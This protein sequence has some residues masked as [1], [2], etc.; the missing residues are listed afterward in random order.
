MKKNSRSLIVYLNIIIIFSIIVFSCVAKNVAYAEPG[1][2]GEVI[3]GDS[4]TENP[5]NTTE[6]SSGDNTGVNQSSPQTTAPSNNQNSSVSNTAPNSSGADVSAMDTRLSELSINCG[7]LIP[8]FSPDIYEYVVYVTKNQESKNCGTLATA[9]DSSATITADGPIE[10]NKEDV[11][12]KI[13]VTGSNGEKTEYVI[14]VHI[15]QDT[16]LVIENELYAITEK[17]DL[18]L[19]PSGFILSDE[20]LNGQE[21]KAAKSSDGNL[22]LVEYLATSNES[23]KWY[24]ISLKNNKI[25]PVDVK[26][27]GGEKYVTVSSEGNLLYGNGL[28]GLGYYL[29]NTETGEIE[30]F[31]GKN[32]NGG[33]NTNANDKIIISGVLIIVCACVLFCAILYKKS[34]RGKE[35]KDEDNKY[36]RPYISLSVDDDISKTKE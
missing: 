10:Y 13:T 18:E 9:I 28:Q 33:E 11:V 36:F 8:E 24:R 32:E 17:P 27:I 22:L 26:E 25:N 15:I 2:V 3:P 19:L 31:I 4:N 20:K 21:I 34:R 30:L 14:N 1:G 35:T 7:T 23:Y 5:T 29:Y 16:E 6:P 12:K